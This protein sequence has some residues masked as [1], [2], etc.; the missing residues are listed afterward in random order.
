ML[1]VLITYDISDNKKRK[2]VEKLLSSYGYRSNY[3]VFEL[4]LT[5]VKYNRIIKTL[6]KITTKQDS[7]KIYFLNRETLKKSF[8]L[9][10][11]KKTFLLE[12]SYV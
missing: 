8:E 3:S 11:N 10:T 12:D 4:I 5:K 1:F 7:I 2:K 6:T 9:H